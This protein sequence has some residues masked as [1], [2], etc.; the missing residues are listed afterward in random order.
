[1]QP[2]EVYSIFMQAPAMMCVFEGPDHV[3]KF[4]NPPYQAL[5]GN[6]PLLGKPIAEAM[7][8][9]KG[10]PIFDLLD[11]VYHTGEPF[12]AHEMQVR[13]FHDNSTDNLGQNYYNF[14]YQALRNPN[15]EITGILVFAYEVTAQVN[16]KSKVEE[17]Y[18]ELAAANLSLRSTNAELASSYQLLLETNRE[19]EEKQESLRSLNESLDARVKRR[20]RQL[21]EALQETQLKSQELE[22]QKGLLS[23]ILGQVPAYIATLQ[24]PDHRFTFFNDRYKT[25]TG[26]RARIGLR[27]SEV[28]PEIAEQ[29]FV[30]LLD[31]VYAT[32]EPFVGQGMEVQLNNASGKPEQR[33][34]DFVYQ[35]LKNK[36]GK[37][38]GI[39][40]FIVDVTEKFIAQTA[41]EEAN[42]QLSRTNVDLDNFVYSA[43][44]DLKNPILNIEGLVIIL[45][46]NLSDAGELPH[47]TQQIFE[48]IQDSISR[49]K[50]NISF[51]SDITKLKKAYSAA[52]SEINLA[53]VVKDVKLDLALEVQECGAEVSIDRDSCATVRSPEKNLRSIVYNLISNAIKYRSPERSLKVIIRCQAE[54]GYHVLS[55]QDNGLGMDLNRDNKL[56]EMFTR[57]HDHVEG[58]GLGLYMVK[59]LIE[60][61][62]GKVEVESEVGKG[63]TFRVYFPA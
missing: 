42:Q 16:A 32:G 45:Q 39:L 30:K 27:A 59:R 18:E 63:S 34:L 33:F 15:G 58:S 20:T 29:G 4:V 11:K 43:S 61:E 36:Q 17:L 10:Q 14:I 40:A 57:L 26:N 53:S 49:F 44:H 13:L 7:P 37:T 46:E 6:R 50:K 56:F 62:G 51:M 5:V 23:E 24:G 55:V 2:D 41:L 52:P 3:F 21:E 47:F 1:M 31:G 48:R 8:E 9:L 60:N 35:P 22:M 28:L 54:D 12:H 19:L 25:L 38:E